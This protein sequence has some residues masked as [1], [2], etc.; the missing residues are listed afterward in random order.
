[1]AHGIAA[2]VRLIAVVFATAVLT[3]IALAIPAHAS[4]HTEWKRCVNN[5]LSERR[6][7]KK[8]DKDYPAESTRDATYRRYFYECIDRGGREGCLLD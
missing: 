1:M 4:D 8:C 2:Y 3:G 7:T 6:D 5:A